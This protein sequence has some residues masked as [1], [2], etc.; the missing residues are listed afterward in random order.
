M[1]ERKKEETPKDK[2]VEIFN[3]CYFVLFTSDTDYAEECTVSLLSIENA[4]VIARSIIQEYEHLAIKL[5]Q[6]EHVIKMLRFYE[7]VLVE[8]EKM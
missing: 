1:V 8:L 6:N 2:A 3:S 5:D 4:K 7:K